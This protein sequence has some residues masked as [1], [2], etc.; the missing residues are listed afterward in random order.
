MPFVV[1]DYFLTANGTKYGRSGME[2]E[3][4]ISFWHLDQVRSES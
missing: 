1:A 3:D 4:L 2:D